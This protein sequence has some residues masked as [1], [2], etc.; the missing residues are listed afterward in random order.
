MKLRT[1]AC[2][3]V[4]SLAAFGFAGCGGDDD[5]NE[6]SAV[7]QSQGKGQQTEQQKKQEAEN[8]SSEASP[9]PLMTGDLTG[10]RVSEPTVYVIHSKKELDA[11][12]KRHNT[13]GIS[14]DKPAAVDFETRQAVGVFLPPQ[15]PGTILAV[16]DIYEQDG[17]IMVKAVKI[18]PGKG[19][20][21]ASKKPRSFA[22]VE[23]RDMKTD[24]SKLLLT[25]QTG[26]DC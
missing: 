22:V 16:N 25:S 7:E 24:K 15:D 6:I 12:V 4:V 13:H 17:T 1:F 18:L 3:F 11:L 26:Q 19:C 20:G 5:N 8:F 23:T 10:V 14:G 21:T 9:V 2:L